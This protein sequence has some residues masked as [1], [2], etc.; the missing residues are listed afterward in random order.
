MRRAAL[1]AALL[2]VVLA[3]L[4]ATTAQAGD[5][6][7]APAP[8]P[9]EVFEAAAVA[10]SDAVVVGT[11][12]VLKKGLATAPTVLR[13]DVERWLKDSKGVAAQGTD[14]TVLL[15]ADAALPA[16]VR[17]TRPT[18]EA[19]AAKRRVLFL[20][21]M[22]A[23]YRLVGQFPL[24]EPESAEKV[25]VLEEEIALDAVADRVERARR[26]V[27]TWSDLLVR[28]TPRRLPSSAPRFVPSSGTSWSRWHSQRA[29]LALARTDLS[30]FDDASLSRIESA[31]STSRDPGFRDALVRVLERA[32]PRRAARAGAGSLATS[33]ESAPSSESS[34]PGPGSPP[35]APAAPESGPAPAPSC[36]PAPPACPPE[37]VDELRAAYAR[38]K[39]T[40]ERATALT[41]LAKEGGR[42]TVRDLLA[43]AMDADAAVRERAAVLLGDLG[44]PAAL[45]PLLHSFPRETDPGVR[46]ALVRAAGCLGDD[47]TVA[48]AVQRLVEPALRRA[49]LFA[50]ARIRTASALAA[51]DE[52]VAAETAKPSP[53]GATIRL[54]AYLKSGSFE[55][56]E[57]VAGR[58]L[59]PDRAAPASPGSGR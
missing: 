24:D 43:A 15:T 36:P 21:P 28:G 38:A 3:V 49:A 26:A 39:T 42:A 18:L 54:V 23:G 52:V 53:D 19:A 2:A 30:A 55:T 33:S 37:R 17:D 5:D 41:V 25:A 8:A 31:L 1:L 35:P 4:P 47:A 45:A 11:A 10:R 34:D 16:G 58:R 59:G 12:R 7:A 46:E 20:S 14:V 27:A 29:L 51:L 13:V 44:D 22:G 9:A 57:R 56:A 50:L 32:D 40:D 48:W 6:P